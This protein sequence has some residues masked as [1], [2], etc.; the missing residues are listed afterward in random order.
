MERF[1]KYDI[2]VVKEEDNKNLGRYSIHPLQSGFGIT[3]GNALRRIMLSNLPG[4]SV[5]AV[6]IKDVTREFQAIPGVVE[7]VTQIILNLKNLVV[8]I[9]ENVISDQMLA[10]TPVEKWPVLK[11]DISE[12][13]D[14]SAAQIECP[15]GFEI[16]NKD[17]HI[18]TKTSDKSK[19][20]TMEIYATRGRGF[21]TFSENR[22]LMKTLLVLPVDSNFS[23]IVKVSYSVEEVKSSK[24]SMTDRLYLE[25]ATNG[26]ITAGDAISMAAKILV[27]H[28]NPLIDIN[29]SLHDLEVM[30]EKSLEVRSQTLSTPIENLDLTVRSYNCL[31]RQGIQTIQ[32]LTERPKNEIEK[33]RNLGKKSLREINKKLLEYGLKLKN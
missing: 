21:K 4:A 3:I 27:E 9:N 28:L 25:V 22:D 12:P 11:L 31:K 23:P 1:I 33:I 32:E 26:A 24:D 14:I 29:Q 20:L 15:A 30:R 7:D 8:V 13:G 16:I 18:C 6:K 19:K 5:F 2:N 10:E 17:L